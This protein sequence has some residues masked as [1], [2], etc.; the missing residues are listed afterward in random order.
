MEL[1][2]GGAVA[3]G[4]TAQAGLGEKGEEPQRKMKG[5][6]RRRKGQGILEAHKPESKDRGE[7]LA[8][9]DSQLMMFRKQDFFHRF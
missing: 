7:G 8:A 9:T 6:E 2:A 3:A 4:K 1:G 5:R